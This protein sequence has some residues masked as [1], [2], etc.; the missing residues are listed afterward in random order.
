[1]NFKN[2]LLRIGFI[3]LTFCYVSS[4]SSQ[5][6]LI[7]TESNLNVSFDLDSN[8]DPVASYSYHICY[9]YNGVIDYSFSKAIFFDNNSEIKNLVKRSG[10]K[11]K[12]AKIKPVISDYQSEGIFHSD[13]KLMYFEHLFKESENRLCIEY[14]KEINDI[15]FIDPIYFHDVCESNIIKVNITVPK[16]LDLKTV[17]INFNKTDQ[18]IK[19]VKN[20]R[21]TEYS[22]S[23]IPKAFTDRYEPSRSCVYPH[24]ILV[25]QKIRQGSDQID[26]FSDVGDL[27]GWYSDL[28]SSVS[29]NTQKF[30]ELVSELTKN[31][32]SDLEKVKSIY[33]WVQD[34]IR[35]VAFEYGIMGFKPED[36]QSVFGNKFGDCKG[37]ANLTKEML[38]LA[39]FDARLTWIGTTDLPYNYNIP[40]LVVD[41]HMICTV[42][43]DKE[44][45]YLDPTEKYGDFGKN[46]G[47]LQGKQVLIEDQSNYI[48]DSIPFN[49]GKDH[50]YLFTGNFDLNIDQLVGEA[51]IKLTGDQKTNVL[52]SIFSMAQNDR[53]DFVRNFTASFDKNYEVDIDTYPNEDYRDKNFLLEFEMIKKNSV[54]NLENEVYVNLEIGNEFG[55]YS[56]DEDRITPIKTSSP[57]F[58]KKVITLNIPN[59][60]KINY[61]P[62]N[63]QIANENYRLNLNFKQID[64]TI[65]YTKT[66]EIV[67]G[68][69]MPK[70]FDKWNSDIKQLSEKY[71]DTIILEK[72]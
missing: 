26:I 48:I 17:E 42:F 62:E 36:C 61:I 38:K 56:I 8:L 50:S 35:Y 53:M 49:G 46:A 70:D 31:K 9:E 21:K 4:S 40:S 1:M 22:L 16:W 18:K 5:E 15:R 52:N 19:I 33:Y 69:L 24:I 66:I 6:D 71:E 59:A 44:K 11:M 13:L 63:L 47:R 54:I 51:E 28:V 2:P 27:Y 7:I 67:N 58:I 65:T 37:M 72:M 43:L 23:N 64:S 39:G 12:K 57:V 3:I 45:Y 10:K 60:W 29:N 55:G 68:I 30:E 32:T 41:N 14:T 34:N 25:P 20:K